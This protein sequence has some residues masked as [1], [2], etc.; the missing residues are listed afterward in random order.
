MPDRE[1]MQIRMGRIFPGVEDM[2]GR[3]FHASY[4]LPV[5]KSLSEDRKWKRLQR[6]SSVEHHIS[7]EEQEQQIEDTVVRLVREAVAAAESDD[8]TA[9]I[10]L[11]ETV[12]EYKRFLMRAAGRTSD[13]YVS[14]EM[15]S[16]A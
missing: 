16:D 14:S 12:E 13:L 6:G 10:E 8:A 3:T 15:A 2:D 11:M 1:A 9:I 5:S 4:M 7:Y